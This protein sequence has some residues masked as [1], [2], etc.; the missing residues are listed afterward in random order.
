MDGQIAWFTGVMEAEGSISAQ[1]YTLPD[2]RVRVTPYVCIVNSDK[3]IL[4][5][6]FAMMAKLTESVRAGPR[7]CGHVGTNK[8]CSTLRVD[9]P[10]V[11]PILE[12]MLPWMRS[13]KRRNAEVVLDY[14]TGRAAG[15][16]IRGTDGR[17]TR[18]GYS[19]DEMEKLCSIRTHK[20]AKSF[21]AI[22]EAPNVT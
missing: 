22:C 4:D 17:I 9:G 3:G 14:I 20:C 19:R 2:G 6:C 5:E 1:V 15:L 11:A 21:E 16:L 10:S 7:W 12:A 18:A 13:E 8:P